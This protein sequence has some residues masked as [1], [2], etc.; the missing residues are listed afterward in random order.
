MRSRKGDA[1]KDGERKKSR[2]HQRVLR[3]P[4]PS[5][6]AHAHR[7]R[8]KAAWRGYK[9][10]CL[11]VDV[12]RR[13]PLLCLPPLTCRLLA[14]KVDHGMRR[15]PRLACMACTSR[16]APDLCAGAC[17]SLRALDG[18]SQRNTVWVDNAMRLYCEN[19]SRITNYVSAEL[20]PIAIQSHKD[21]FRWYRSPES[22]ATT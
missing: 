11:V 15:N 16:I 9:E 12:S 22:A 8:V 6:F 13:F 14:C 18:S 2:Y 1:C 3:I 7:H 19:R 20:H 5:F 17:V 21:I 4:P 10:R